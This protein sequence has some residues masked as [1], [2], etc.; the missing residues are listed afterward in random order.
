LRFQPGATRPAPCGMVRQSRIRP[1]QPRSRRIGRSGWCG[2]MRLGADQ[3]GRTTAESR[4]RRR[5]EGMPARGGSGAPHRGPDRG[6]VDP[7]WAA[8]DK[9]APPGNRLA[10][11]SPGGVWARDIPLYRRAVP[12]QRSTA[13]TPHLF[14]PMRTTVVSP[15]KKQGRLMQAR[16]TDPLLAEPD[17]ALLSS[18]RMW[19]GAGRGRFVVIRGCPLRTAQDCCEWHACGTEPRMTPVSCRV[20]GSTMTVG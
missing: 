12:G 18:V 11:G 3:L 14:K 15:R 17:R 8:P 20:V 16:S 1:G 4:L 10:R 5:R 13:P 2:S 19:S 7:R 6:K 9:R